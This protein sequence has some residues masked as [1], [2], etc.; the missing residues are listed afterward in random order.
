[1]FVEKI[2]YMTLL[3]NIDSLYDTQKN[4]LLDDTRCNFFA[5]YDTLVHYMTYKDAI[6]PSATL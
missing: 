3:V 2:Y 4:S 1:M 6:A 5:G